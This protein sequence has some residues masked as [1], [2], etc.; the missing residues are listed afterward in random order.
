MLI[1]RTF[2]IRF[3]F[4]VIN[5]VPNNKKI[6]AFVKINVFYCFYES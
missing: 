2:L 4:T 3:I 6:Y 1:T 5:I